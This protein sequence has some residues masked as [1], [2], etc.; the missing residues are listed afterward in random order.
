MPLT[1]L[2]TILPASLTESGGKLGTM[3]LR[4]LHSCLW[5]SQASFYYD[6]FKE[7]EK[8]ARYLTFYFFYIY[9]Y[10]LYICSY[11][12]LYM[13]TN[14]HAQPHH[15]LDLAIQSHNSIT[16]LEPGWEEQLQSRKSAPKDQE[17]TFLRYWW[18][19][20]GSLQ[21]RQP[22]MPTAKQTAVHTHFTSTA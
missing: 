5:S 10:I 14:K 2:K 20:T 17:G 6:F 1:S 13:H 18:P 22:Q 11:Q 9:T 12:H 3:L 8:T 4:H 7:K 16:A 19:L 21:H 15:R